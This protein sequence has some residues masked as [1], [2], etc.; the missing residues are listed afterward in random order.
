MELILLVVLVVVVLAGFALVFSFLKTGQ[1]NK[2][3]DQSFSMLQNQLNELNRTMQSQTGEVTKVIQTQHGQSTQIIQD[4][5]KEIT[6]LKETNRQV[7]GFTDQLKQLQDILKNPK[8]RGILGEFYLEN[9]LQNVLGSTTQYELQHRLGVD[10][11]TDKEL[12]PDAVIFIGDRKLAIDAKFSLENYNKLVEERDPS[13]KEQLEKNFKQDIKNRIDETSKY[14]RPDLGTMDI[15]I[16]FIP[17]EGIFS[18]ILGSTRGSGINAQDLLEYASREKKVQITSPT[19]FYAMLQI[20]IEL[21]RRAKIQEST[22]DILKNIGL[23]HKHLDRYGEHFKKMGTHLNTTVNMYKSADKEY[24]K[25][26]KD[27]FKLSGVGGEHELLE[28]ESPTTEEE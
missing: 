5:V 24:R 8:Q 23:L 21:D 28:L 4:V 26:D 14:V 17:A 3:Q 20:A 16:M 19:T 27:I 1:N 22:K 9:L 2:A 10:E 12:I 7:V 18:D 11:K 13:I 15:A 25:I 6:I